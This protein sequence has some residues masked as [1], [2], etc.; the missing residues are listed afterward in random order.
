MSFRT[1][2]GS[3]YE[4]RYTE[5]GSADVDRQCRCGKRHFLFEKFLHVYIT[6][7]DVL[8]SIILLA[9]AS[10]R[11]SARPFALL[12]SSEVLARDKRFQPGGQLNLNPREAEVDSAVPRSAFALALKAFTLDVHVRAAVLPASGSLLTQKDNEEKLPIVLDLKP[13]DSGHAKIEFSVT[14]DFKPE[15]LVVCLPVQL[16]GEMSANVWSICWCRAIWDFRLPALK[17]R[18]ISLFGSLQSN[19]PHIQVCLIQ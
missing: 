18:H 8:Y 13:D 17:Q 16:L 11:S 14:R 10:V 19:S 5:I 3:I 6:C 4:D 15:P 2:Q 1:D 9:Y 7:G 12:R